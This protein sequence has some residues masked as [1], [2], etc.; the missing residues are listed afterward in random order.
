MVLPTAAAVAH[1]M[2]NRAKKGDG[3]KSFL[4]PGRFRPVKTKSKN[5]IKQLGRTLRP[6]ARAVRSIGKFFGFGAYTRHRPTGHASGG[7]T[8]NIATRARN[9]ISR[10]SPP[11][12]LPRYLPLHFS[13]YRR[14]GSHFGRR[15]YR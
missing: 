12:K 8:F 10:S 1:Y 6:A 2:V 15:L 11:R 5:T 9:P 14:D 7:D 4:S 3:G 13:N